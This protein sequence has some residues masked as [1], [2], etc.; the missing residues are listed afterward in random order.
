MAQCHGDRVCAFTVEAESPGLG[1]QAVLAY[2]EM[3]F[4]EL[5]ELLTVSDFLHTKIVVTAILSAMACS[6]PGLWL[7]LRRQS[8]M[9]DAL[10]HTALPGW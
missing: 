7:V 9:G 2:H 8:L 1:R 4:R 5:W 3:M 6:L 10:S